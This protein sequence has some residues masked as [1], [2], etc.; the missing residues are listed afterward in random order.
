[1]P[2]VPPPPGLVNLIIWWVAGLLLIRLAWW[3]S[4]SQATRSGLISA[5]ASYLRYIVFLVCVIFLLLESFFHFFVSV[6]DLGCVTLS[7]RKWFFREWIPLNEQGY[8]DL[9]HAPDRFQ[10]KRVIAVFGDSFA[11]GHGI[12]SIRDRYSGVLQDMLSDDWIV[13]TLAQPG[14]SAVEQTRALREFT[15]N[16]EFVVLSA[17]HNDLE[18][19]ASEQNKD[20]AGFA[21]LEKFAFIEIIARRSY[22]LNYAFWSVFISSLIRD[23]SG[24]YAKY[25]H[26]LHSDKA[27]WTPYE[28]QLAE[29]ILLARARGATPMVVL[30]PMLY[31]PPASA[32]FD[33]KVAELC[34]GM[35]V[36][37]LDT[38]M[39]ITD[40]PPLE[41]IL[42]P[43]DSHPSIL[44]HQRVGAALAELVIR[45]TPQ[46]PDSAA[47]TSSPDASKSA[48]ENGHPD[49]MQEILR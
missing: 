1:M 38:R 36:P 23:D 28:Q 47:S 35:G 25:L 41:R 16:P 37:L 42:N 22:V 13:P 45:L 4:R 34:E 2:G 19:I 44:V 17:Y 39:L 24:A 7:S 29:A 12:E 10:G 48:F 14:W 27:V 11:A 30:F 3:I 15:L 18:G 5:A 8:R 49:S 21:A 33:D 26:E 32:G 40:V 46:V 31:H 6:P 9:S 43:M 20:Y